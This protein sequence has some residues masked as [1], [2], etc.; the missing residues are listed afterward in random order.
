MTI[1]IKKSTDG[2]SPPALA[3]TAGSYITLLD[4]LLVTTMGWTKEFSGTNL[5]CYRPPVGTN[6]FRLYVDDTSTSTAR[7][8]AYEEMTS[9]SA[10]TGPFPTTA[11]QSGGLYAPKSAAAPWKFFSNGK[12]F[13]LFVLT[14]GYWYAHIFGDFLSDK[15]GDAFNTV[16]I[17]QASNT[18]YPSKIGELT[19]NQAAVLTG[20]F[21]ARPYTQVG[22][23]VAS[24]KWADPVRSN[25]AATMGT[26]GTAY[27]APINGAL[28]MSPVWL[29]EGAAGT[30]SGPRGLLPGIWSPL[31]NYPLTPGDTFAGAG[32]LF[33]RTF[34]AVAINTDTM[35]QCFMETSDTW[36]GI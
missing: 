11:Q 28:N 20:H 33:G 18:S 35:A 29:G 16:H 24:G 23:S 17:G 26:G 14:G 36:G 4:F 30:T 31:H 27:P 1:Y 15:A 32:D 6:R 19:T 5:A 10:G 25:N 22:S 7:L 12:I 9:I 21:I 3:A 8:V 34:E 2:G 13:Y